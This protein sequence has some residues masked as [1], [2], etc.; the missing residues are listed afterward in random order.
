M[1]LRSAIFDMDGTLIDSMGMWKYLG[2]SYLRSSGIAPQERFWEDVQPE[3]LLHGAEYY[4]THYHLPETPAQIL[5]FWEDYVHTF[6]SRKVQPKPGVV[7]FLNLLRIE[8]VAMFVATNTDRPLAEAALKCT[9]LDS[10]FRGMLTCP[11][12]GSRK[13]YSADIFER[14]MTRLRSNKRDTVV[15]EDS[16]PAIRTAK[17]AGFR[18]AGVYDAAFPMDQAEIAALSDY[19]IR[20]FEEMYEQRRG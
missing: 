20:S 2:E 9:G 1:R 7:K 15:F 13:S 5:D 17:A 4:H 18:V 16:L 8:G 11:E 3:S 10:F 19:Y 12:V 6:Y 14:S